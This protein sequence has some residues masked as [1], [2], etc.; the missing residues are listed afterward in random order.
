MAILIDGQSIDEMTTNAIVVSAS[1]PA[2]PFYARGGNADW[3]NYNHNRELLRMFGQRGEIDADQAFEVFSS[4]FRMGWTGRRLSGEFQALMC[5]E[6]LAWATV[7]GLVERLE[8]PR[9]RLLEP[10]PRW[11]LCGPARK[12]VPTQVHGLTGVAAIAAELTWH[13]ELKRRERA[14]AKRTAA[15]AKSVRDMAMLIGQHAPETK[16]GPRLSQFAVGQVDTL[17]SAVELLVDKMRGMQVDEA[18]RIHDYVAEL[19]SPI[20]SCVAAARVA[21]QE[22]DMNALADAFLPSDR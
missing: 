4:V 11:E 2:R 21:R 20:E 5:G 16:L 6:C 9:W 22:A 3:A 19:W 17:P 13:R 15:L 10:E 7:N 14:R 1:N 12:Q 18:T 8:G